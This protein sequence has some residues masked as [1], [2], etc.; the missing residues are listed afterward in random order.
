MDQIIRVNRH[1]D[2]RTSLIDHFP[3]YLICVKCDEPMEDCKCWSSFHDYNSR[4]LIK[5]DLM[6]MLLNIVNETDLLIEQ[7]RNESKLEGLFNKMD[8]L[9]DLREKYNNLCQNLDLYYKMLMYRVAN[10]I[11]HH[12]DIKTF[13]DDVAQEVALGDVVEMSKYFLDK[14]SL[15][16][17]VAETAPPPD[18]KENKEK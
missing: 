2:L 13:L 17:Y 18:Y 12:D 1:S 14:Y 8:L 9:K 5:K 7:E 4:T 3:G 11:N 16:D 15:S 10:E 6:K